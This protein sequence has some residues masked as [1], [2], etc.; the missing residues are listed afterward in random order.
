MLT[1]R[2]RGLVFGSGRLGRGRGWEGGSGDEGLGCR[3]VFGGR[4]G[5]LSKGVGGGWFGG[6][7]WLLVFLGEVDAGRWL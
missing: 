4:G 2:I 6:K 5:G 1:S 7:R 3:L